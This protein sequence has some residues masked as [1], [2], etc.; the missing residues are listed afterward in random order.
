VIPEPGALADEELERN[1]LR[2]QAESLY[3]RASWAEAATMIAFGLAF[4]VGWYAWS[5]FRSGWGS[6]PTWEPW[7]GFILGSVLG[8]ALARPFAEWLRLQARLAHLQLR[9]EAHAQRTFV[10]ST[11]TVKHLREI[12]DGQR[13][14]ESRS[15][16]SGPIGAVDSD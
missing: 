12:A 6:H 3:R 14:G 2:L 13:T 7:A 11:T 5:D 1:A 15:V 16:S 9:I 10:S 4:S 8:L